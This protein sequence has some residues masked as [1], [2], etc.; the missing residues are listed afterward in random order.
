[1][2]L[3]S[4]FPL[5]RKDPV[6]VRQA[7]EE[8]GPTFVKLGQFLALR[9]DL[10]PQ[11]YCDEL[12]TLSDRAAPFP[13][14]VARRI[15]TEDLGQPP[16]ACFASIDSR[17]IA[18]ASLAQAHLARTHDGASV[19][20]KVQ[21]EDMPR[22]VREDLR[23]VR[24][25]T[26]ILEATGASFAI[27]PRMVLEEL[28]GWLHQELDL[29]LELRNLERMYA[30]A[31]D[32]TEW[33]I[34]RPFPELSGERVVTSGYLAGVP[35][36]ELLHEIRQGRPERIRDL[37]LDPNRLARNLLWAVLAQIFQDRL[38]HADTHPGN[39][40]ALPGNQVGFV[41]FGLVS[42]LDDTFRAGMARYLTAIY[43]G[44]QEA[45]YRALTELLIP[46]D[47]TDLDAFHADFAEATRA[48]ISQRDGMGRAPE[49]GRSPV[50]QY[51]VDVL[52]AARRNHLRIPPTLLS[53]YRSLLTAETVANR[54]GSRTNLRSV[55]KR[56]FVKLQRA[57]MRVVP[58]KEQVQLLLADVVALLKDGPAQLHQLLGDLADE[59]LWLRVRTS[60]SLKDRREENGR[61]RLVV[62]ALLQVGLS[63]LLVGAERLPWVDQFPVR[64][65]LAALL[66]LSWVVLAV[67]WR[68][69]P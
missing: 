4:L 36:T 32:H 55:G 52:S 56:F 27:P 58:D 16:E 8:L 5:K 17:P 64:G 49:S 14:E 38:F 61:A 51:M 7:L 33:R 65:G 34:P 9:P 23:R 44:R 57:E 12:M 30:L 45:M 47:D 39:L 62:L 19:I 53:M 3:L 24:L 21:R 43:T 31:M 42:T 15:I 2:S 50:G 59:R 1:M 25:L 10:I 40:I 22:R 13:W 63:L 26:S 18:A 69:L 66:G 60:T 68:R 6:A 29:R 67:Q 11:A 37:G 48:W 54:L 20:V 46:S 28:E 41:D 35:F